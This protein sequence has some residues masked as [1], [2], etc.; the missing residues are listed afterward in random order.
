MFDLVTYII[1]KTC[2]IYFLF[3]PMNLGIP[4][5]FN[6]SYLNTHVKR[7]NLLCKLSRNVTGQSYKQK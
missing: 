6:R 2:F 4:F 7:E 1:Y 3:F 5:Y